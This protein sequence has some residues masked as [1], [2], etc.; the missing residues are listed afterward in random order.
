VTEAG[1]SE[2]QCEFGGSL[3]EF[4]GVL[5][6]SHT[7]K[8]VGGISDNCAPSRWLSREDPQL[9]TRPPTIAT[10]GTLRLE[11]FLFSLY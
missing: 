8:G 6:R 9:N 10:S 7:F 3:W 2:L 5:R 1:P 11:D 4:G